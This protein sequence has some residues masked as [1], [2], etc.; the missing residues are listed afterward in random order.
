MKI[1]IVLFLLV[2]TNLHAGFFGSSDREQIEEVRG[3]VYKIQFYSE[4]VVIGEWIGSSLR[5]RR[6]SCWFITVEGKIIQL[7]GTI[8][9]VMIR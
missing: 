5:L 6:G 9:A 2:S 1:I 3:H 4:G 7:S 8:K